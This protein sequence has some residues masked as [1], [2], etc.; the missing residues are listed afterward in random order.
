MTLAEFKAL[1]GMQDRRVRMIF[2]DGQ[3]LIATLLS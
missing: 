2:E 3:E 1:R